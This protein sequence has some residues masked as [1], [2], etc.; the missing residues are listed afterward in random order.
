[1]D[2]VIMGGGPAGLSASYILSLNKHQAMVFE[3]DEVV[4]GISRTVHKNGFSFDM[5]EMLLADIK[6][7][8]DF[9]K[10]NPKFIKSKT[11]SH[12]KHT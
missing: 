12:F 4:G 7:C 5:A 2:T 3:Q 9:F 1:M 11:G 6:R 10:K 8:L